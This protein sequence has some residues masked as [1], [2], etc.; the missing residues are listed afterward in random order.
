MSAGLNVTS[1]NTSS[2]TKITGG[3]GADRLQAA[4][5]TTADILIGGAGDDIL[6]ANAG[7]STLTGGT[8][9]DSFRLIVASS[10][11]NSYA[12][13]T[14]FQA[15]DLLDFQTDLLGFV[16][17]QAGTGL[18]NT[19]G[20]SDY[21][22]DAISAAAID[23]AAWFQYGGNTYVVA[24]VGAADTLTFTTGDD[25]IVKLTGLVDLSNASFNVGLD[26]ISL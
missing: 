14:D 13:I 6:V 7:L 23:E 4:A 21:V 10:N 17:T 11:I 22:N 8:G 5:G 15:G 3:N 26:T 20:F 1:L 25:Y 2:A 16:N 18:A 19:A 12:T 24:D 9:A